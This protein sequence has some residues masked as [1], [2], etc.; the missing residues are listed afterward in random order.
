[1]T[2]PVNWA[3]L[4]L[5]IDRPSYGL[6]LYNRYLRE[7]GDVHP[8]S[9][10]SHAYSAL[11]ALESRGLIEIAPGLGIGRQPKPHYRATPLGVRAY[12]DWLVAQIDIEDRR[13]EMWVRQLAM[14][15]RNPRAAVSVLGRCRDQCLQLGSRLGSRP[16]N[17]AADSRG[18][19]IELVAERRRIAN[20]GMLSWLQVASAR[21]EN[22]A[23]SVA[24]DDP[25]QT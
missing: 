20:G 13:Q 21:F 12:E 15:G 10:A 11:D 7:Y 8:I 18:L 19:L 16:G 1:M 14:F 4:G 23:G 9:E 6:E 22:R 24:H 5:V 25:P 3:M 17:S 2:S